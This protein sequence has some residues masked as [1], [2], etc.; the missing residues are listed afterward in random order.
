MRSKI[1]AFS[2]TLLTH[3]LF[4]Q[5]W[6][7]ISHENWNTTM[8]LPPYSSTF[9]RCSC[10][11]SQFSVQSS[12]TVGWESSRQ[13][14]ISRLCTRLEALLLLLG[15]FQAYQCQERKSY[16]SWRFSLAKFSLL[17]QLLGLVCCWSLLVLAGSS[18]AYLHLVVISSNCPSRWN[19]WQPS[20]PFSTSQLMP[21]PWSQHH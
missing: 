7:C 5:F 4:Q 10:T 12:P 18:H 8:T 14:C 11:S 20:F 9:S 2:K 13:S 21:V 3:S 6:F 19:S 1:P 16:S 15:P 17:G